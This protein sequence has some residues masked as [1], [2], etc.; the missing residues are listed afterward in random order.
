MLTSILQIEKKMHRF[1]LPAYNNMHNDSSTTSYNP[2]ANPTPPLTSDTRSLRTSYPPSIN[3][4][5]V[6]GAP[7]SRKGSEPSSERGFAV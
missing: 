5:A 6:E 7:S 3:G 4:D 1:S 2:S